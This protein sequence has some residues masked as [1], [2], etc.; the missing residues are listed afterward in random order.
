MSKKTFLIRL[1]GIMAF[2]ILFI[3]AVI[4]AE[5]YYDQYPGNGFLAEDESLSYYRD[6]DVGYLYHN[7]TSDVAYNCP[8]NFNVPDGS[9][10]F[11]KSIGIRY[12]DNL[13]IGQISIHLKRENLYTGAFHTVASWTSGTLNAS[14]SVQTYSKG[15]EPGVKLVDTKKFVYWLYISFYVSG[16][17]NPS[18]DLKL[19]QVRIH[20]GT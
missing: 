7:D 5:Q 4:H 17:V 14:S 13:T 12:L 6:W 9:V 19:Y 16:A 2:S 10:Y 15:T 11:I 1:I 3:T 20:Y 8:V 18:T